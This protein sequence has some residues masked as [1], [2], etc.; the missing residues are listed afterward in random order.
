MGMYIHDVSVCVTGVCV[1]CGPVSVWCSMGGGEAPW[2]RFTGVGHGVTGQAELSGEGLTWPPGARGRGFHRLVL[3]DLLPLQGPQG[4][5]SMGRVRGLPFW[6]G[7][8][9]WGGDCFDKNL[10][11][12]WAPGT[13]VWH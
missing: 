1:A 13:R 12:P 7:T 8:A 6:K 5:A 9:T 11:R 3:D 2:R 4:L 10:D